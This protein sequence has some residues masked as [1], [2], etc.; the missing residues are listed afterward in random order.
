[1]SRIVIIILLVLAIGGSAIAIMR[2]YR[3][4]QAPVVEAKTQSL[5]LDELTVNLADTREAH[6]LKAIID[7]HITGAKPMDSFMTEWH[8]VVVDGTIEILSSHTYA[9]LLS[10]EG[11]RALKRE[12]RDYLSQRLKDSGWEVKDILFTEF[13]ME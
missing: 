5:K 10:F 3:P 1:M 2:T 13:V 6:Y 11:K 8:S 12:L 4:A 7:L 9:S